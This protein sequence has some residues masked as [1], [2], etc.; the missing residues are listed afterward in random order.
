MCRVFV[1][2]RD[3]GLDLVRAGYA[4]H[5]KHFADEQT[6]IERLDYQQAESDA[7]AS[8]RGLWED[9]NSEPSWEYRARKRRMT[10][11]R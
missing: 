9:Q 4:W 5:F 11:L 10:V 7:Q 2:N 6:D 1:G 8:C 3:V